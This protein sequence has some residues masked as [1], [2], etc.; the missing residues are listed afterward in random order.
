MSTLTG[1]VQTARS[2]VP[3]L[4]G[5]VDVLSRLVWKLDTRGATKFLDLIVDVPSERMEE[6]WVRLRRDAR[7]LTSIPP[8][9]RRMRL[10]SPFPQRRRRLN[11]VFRSMASEYPTGFPTTMQRRSQRGTRKAQLVRRGHGWPEP[12][13]TVISFK[14][15]GQ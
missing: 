7:K 3:Q 9:V 8:G 1:A 10:I 15:F 6:A 11:D 4:D 13:G 2:E 12:S 5:V 14:L